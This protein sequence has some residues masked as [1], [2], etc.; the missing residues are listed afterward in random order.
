M[1][2]GS[3]VLYGIPNCDTVRKAR[4]WL[5]RHGIVYE[6]RDLRHP[7]P[8]QAMLEHWI[9][10]LGLDAVLNRR[11]MTWRRLDAAEQ[12]AV[13]DRASA[14]VLMLTRP[15]VIRRPI[16]ERGALLLAGFDEQEWTRQLA[17]SESGK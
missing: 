6:F 12:A 4:S 13:V 2:T 1:N 5:G 15:T 16:L 3:T 10:R 7:V 14:V 8:G 9:D 17:P 11:G